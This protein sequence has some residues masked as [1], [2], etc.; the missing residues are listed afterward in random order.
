MVR[1]LYNVQYMCD[2]ASN[3]IL[4]Y[5]VFRKRNDTGT[6][7][8]MI[9]MTQRI[10][11]KR[12]KRVHADSGYCSLLELQDCTAQDVELM[13]PVA[14]ERAPKGRPTA[15]GEPQLRMEAFAWDEEHQQRTCPSGHSMRKACRSK[16]PRG[17]SR[18][19]IELRVEQSPDRC[20]SCPLA[21]QC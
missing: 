11:G 4:A 10:T 1:P 21:D 5:D 20:G 8:P 3:V 13:A 16:D 9:K 2:F 14:I 18:F 6:L 15:S 7:L 17:D 19:V 12:L